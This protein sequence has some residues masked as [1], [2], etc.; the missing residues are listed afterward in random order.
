MVSGHRLGKEKANKR[1]PVA[2]LA[3]AAAATVGTQLS[4]ISVQLAGPA[5]WP[6]SLSLLGFHVA[7]QHRVDPRLVA[8]PLRLEEGQHV[9]V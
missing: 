9:G 1:D 6:W 5:S 8:P 2:A 3:R 4:D 7:A